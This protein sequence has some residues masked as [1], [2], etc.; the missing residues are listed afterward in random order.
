MLQIYANFSYFKEALTKNPSIRSAWGG[1]AAPPAVNSA[2]T[3]VPRRLP[4]VGQRKRSMRRSLRHL[5]LLA[6]GE[7]GGAAKG[8]MVGMRGNPVWV[9]IPTGAGESSDGLST[10]FQAVIWN[11]PV[12]LFGV[13]P[14]N[15]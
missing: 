4:L 14:E 13:F 3:A 11:F 6:G 1:F 2:Y 9:W 15:D 10:I 8:R 7:G 12:S 5:G